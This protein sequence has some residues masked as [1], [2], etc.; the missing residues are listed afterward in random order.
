MAPGLVS[1]APSLAGREARTRVGVRLGERK[2]LPSPQLVWLEECSLKRALKL[3][4][5]DWE[6]SL[7]GA[8]ETIGASF[9]LRCWVVDL[10]APQS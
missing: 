7:N 5:R 10:T 8:Q 3:E 1:Q 6:E 2:Q 9:I 4:R